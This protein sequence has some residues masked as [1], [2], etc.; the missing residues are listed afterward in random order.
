MASPLEATAQVLCPVL[1]GRE[2]EARILRRAVDEAFSG[3]GGLVVVAGEAGV[4]KSRLVREAADAA[5]AGG[6]TVLVGRAVETATPT[7]FR[8]LSEALLAAFR[9]SGPPR[10][11]ELAPFHSALGRLLPHWPSPTVSG[12]GDSDVVLGEGLLRLL[13][14]VGNGR[15]TVLVAED[16]HWADPE[17]LAVLDY[18]SDAAPTASVLCLMTVRSD[19]PSQGLHLARRLQARRSATLVELERLD[20]EASRQMARASLGQGDLPERI[21]RMVLDR[22]EGLPF[23][24]EE[25][26]AA[27]MSSHALVRDETGWQV[28]DA[29]VPVPA[30]VAG[31]VRARLASLDDDVL[32]IVRA[33]ALLG[34]AFDWSLLAPALGVDEQDVLRGL[35]TAAE[36]QLLTVGSDGSYAFRHALTHDAV[37]AQLLLAERTTLARG[38]LEAVERSH[39]GLEDQWCELAAGLAIES[40]EGAHAA[41]LLLE[42]GR[43]ALAAGALVIAE[44]ALRD[45]AARG[46]G[47][48]SLTAEIDDVLTEVLAVS[49]AWD[50]VLELGNRLLTTLV[51]LSVS[52]T[53]RARVHLRI[54]RAANAAGQ[55]HLA[56]SH[57]DQARR[58][59]AD[60]GDDETLARVDAL[61]A[62]VAIDE[63]QLE[64]AETLARSALARAEHIDLPDV[65][66]EAL[67][68]I[69]RNARLH[70]LVAAEAA[71]ARALELAE[72]HRLELWRMRALHELG[73]IE[74]F[75]H[76]T[77]ARM[78]EARDLAYRSGAWTLAAN[79]DLQ[80]AGMFAVTFRPEECLAAGARAVDL[81]RRLRL[82]LVRA[83]AFLHMA[84]AYAFTARW[85]EMEAALDEAATG[86][87]E[88]PDVDA[89]SLGNV[90]A[91][92]HLLREERSEAL[93]ALDRAMEVARSSRGVPPGP[94]F[95]LWPLVR[96]VENHEGEQA[97]AEIRGSGRTTPLV[98]TMLHFADAVLGGRRGRHDEA[99]TAFL[100]GDLVTPEANYEGYRHLCRR[101]AAEAAVRDGWGEPV[102]WLRESMAFFEANGHE[103]VAA[104]C[105]ALL[106]KAGAPVPRRRKGASPVPPEL[107]AL[108]IT[109]REVDV[110][111][112]VGKGLSNSEIAERLY[113]SARTVEKHVEHLMTK[114]G[115]SDRRGLAP[116]AERLN[117]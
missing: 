22:A 66:C 76:G 98:D 101:L 57:L 42:A 111:A 49:G 53:R 67:E 18:L 109:G 15:A 97:L 68:V 59:G 62:H 16:V 88:H 95:M 93:E 20:D 32:A 1:I 36:S 75:L 61:A 79:V 23:L 58:L 96:V 3:R 85:P 31:A 38:L 63:Q 90:R 83:M 5:R 46:A 112:L 28:R 60:A 13:E 44:T 94:F 9:Q 64:E 17:T 43:R 2:G 14:A 34:R 48:L 37:A 29:S 100:R 69:G 92:A 105:R 39:P 8:P 6:A 35:R 54:A 26:L 110:L 24:I 52:T 103:P 114:A 25:V 102:V 80:L 71:F 65:A 72:D 11:P 116:L 4:G 117:T 50:G 33:A 107:R 40:G 55:G 45:A 27:A 51:E 47:D 73:T 91:L 78:V 10:L 41:R 82:D 77:V 56:R 70:D 81:A 106:S 113:I 87:G 7:A 115:A 19:A 89:Y 104:S 74:M 99:L 84:T 30:T 86:A 21:E 108:G 12:S